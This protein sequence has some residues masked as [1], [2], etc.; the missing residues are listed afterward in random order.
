MDSEKKWYN[1]CSS[2]VKSDHKDFV[3]GR[4]LKME[5][6]NNILY[7]KNPPKTVQEEYDLKRSLKDD[8]GVTVLY[9]TK[10]LLIRNAHEPWADKLTLVM[11]RCVNEIAYV[12]TSNNKRDN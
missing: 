12:V 11:E 4:V 1:S 10:Q 7:M 2:Y 5:G 3:L 6:S 9:N 8:E